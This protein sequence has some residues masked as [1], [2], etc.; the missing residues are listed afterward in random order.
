MIKEICLDVDQSSS[1]SAMF[2]D[3]IVLSIHEKFCGKSMYG[4]LTVRSYEEKQMRDDLALM[5]STGDDTDSFNGDMRIYNRST[6]TRFEKKSR[7]RAKYCWEWKSRS[8]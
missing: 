6:G 1:K 5:I 4:S 3:A 7:F 2:R 8:K